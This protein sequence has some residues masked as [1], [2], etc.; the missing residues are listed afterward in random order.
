M[1]THLRSLGYHV[2][3]AADGV[4][5]LEVALTNPGAIDLLLSDFI[6]PKMGG[7]ELAEELRK[8]TPDL[9]AIFISGYFGQ[10]AGNEGAPAQTYFVHKPIS[11]RQLAATVRE[12]LDGV[13]DSPTVKSSSG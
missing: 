11:M 7:R 4:A 9:K 1:V 5:A 13:H 2:L 6:M 3:P 8:T 10:D 12:V